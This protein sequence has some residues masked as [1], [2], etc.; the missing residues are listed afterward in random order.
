VGRALQIRHSKSDDAEIDRAFYAYD[1]AGNPLSKETVD[2]VFAYGYD[3]LDQ[4]VSENNPASGLTT[5]SYDAFNDAEMRPAGTRRPGAGDG[6]DL[7]IRTD[8]ALGAQ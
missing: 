1:A 8:I 5:W 3:E 4:L 2:G 6:A 7:R